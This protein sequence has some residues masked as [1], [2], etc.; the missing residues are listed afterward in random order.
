MRLSHRPGLRRQSIRLSIVG[1]SFCT[2]V[3]C[4][5]IMD[6]ASAQGK[7][8]RRTRL[9]AGEKGSVTSAVQQPTIT[10]GSLQLTQSA[11]EAWK[12]EPIDSLI[13]DLPKG[14]SLY[15]VGNFSGT[16]DRL[17]DELGKLGDSAQ[18]IEQTANAIVVYT[19]Q[20]TAAT[21][22]R[23]RAQQWIDVV[24]PLTAKRKLTPTLQTYLAQVRDAD[25]SVGPAG[26]ARA[27][28]RLEV[29]PEPGG[30]GVATAADDQAAAAADEPKVA[31]TFYLFR[32]QP[33]A[34]VLESVKTAGGEVVAAGSD[35]TISVVRAR[36]PASQVENL[37]KSASVREVTLDP[38]F[39]K[40]NDVALDIL[41]KN[42]PPFTLPIHG[43]G[44]IVGHSDS[45]IDVGKNDGS[46][47]KSLQGR[48]KQVFA[49][50]R[51][52]SGGSAG[53]WS[54][55]GGHGTHT[56]GSILGNGI[57][58]GVAPA[59]E[60]VHQSLDNHN[61]G[62]GGIPTPLGNLFDPAYQAGARIHSNSWGV[63][64]IV[65]GVGNING[66][67]YDRGQEVDSWTWNNGSP[68]DML[69]VFSAGNDGDFQVANGKMTVTSPG[70]AKNC[71]TIGASENVRPTAGTNSDNA[72]DL[73]RF[74]SRGPT[75]EN[76][77]KPDLVAPGTWIASCRTHGEQ[78]PWLDDLETVPPAAG[79]PLAWI[80][81]PGFQ[82][83]AA[84]AGASSGTRAWRFERAV[85]ASF[86]DVLL[87]PEITVPSGHGLTLQFRVRGDISG[88][89]RFQIGFR[90]GGTT[91][92]Y[93][94]TKARKFPSWMTI[95]APVPSVFQGTKV[96][97][98]VIATQAAAPLPANV[99]LS[100]DDFELT[101]FS[102][103]D[104]L[105]NIG[106]APLDGD[107]DNDFTFS[108]GTS[109]AAPIAAGCATLVRQSL[110]DSGV[111]SPS[112]ELVKAILINSADAHSGPRPNFLAGWG[113]INLRR[114]I[115]G[116]YTFD[117]ESS[118]SE[119]ENGNYDVDVPEGTKQL[120]ATLVWADEP[121]AK[122]VNDLDLKLVSPAGQETLAAD[123]DANSPDRT[124]NVEGIDVSQP[125]AGVW[126]AVV[127]AHKITPN[128]NQPFA[129]VISCIPE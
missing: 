73:A 111:E 87:T 94:N 7:V 41:V 78:I 44:Q 18:I 122:L 82:L 25:A 59:A 21:I 58:A 5:L 105:A 99:N 1:R 13:D 8:G 93:P 115:E 81:S 40:Q 53:D 64:A 14:K 55:R 29:V 97:F 100:L 127:T 37:A 65:P 96:R 126:K 19:D 17:R 85:G 113:L 67:A 112:A 10:M 3:L 56:A 28:E 119:G 33:D 27:F 71:L 92:A 23:D 106:T 116:D 101:T 95:S 45:G 54:D 110:V 68:R 6:A 15:V 38:Q 24:E 84:P 42:P 12:A 107:E 69:I 16:T 123:P 22:T 75:R 83:S 109:M 88:L 121:N 114:A 117:F 31:V 74:S 26:P 77:V 46:M 124:N 48:I 66:G 86:Q 125:A 43:E 30:V 129:I 102:S 4:V 90:Q 98:A 63:P 9:S 35:E 79:G 70:T 118:L 49:L 62:L 39:V 80:A 104:S 72:L 20:A 2:L 47:H 61:G 51:P 11:G 103:W 76:R 36:V 34:Q 89:E 50:G 128:L 120:R 91:Q 108:G 60:L 52:G 57:H 32:Q